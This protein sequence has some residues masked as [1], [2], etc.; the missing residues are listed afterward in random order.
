MLTRN[1]M[2]LA[3]GE[4][5]SRLPLLL[6]EVTLARLLGP[7]V[8]GIWSIIQTFATY[9]N[10]LH[11]GVSSS[12]A[13]REPGLIELGSPSEVLANRAAAY[14]FQIMVIVVVAGLLVTISSVHDDAFDAIGGLSTALALLVVILAQQ[15]TIS[16]QASALNEYKVIASSIARLVYAFAF[17][18]IGLFVVR[19]DP[20]LLWLTLGWAV[21]LALAL[22]LLNV[23]A[24]GILIFPRLDYSRTISMLRDGFPIMV[25]GLLRFGLMSVDKIA[26]FWVAR[27]EAVG[28]YGI[29]SLAASVT[30]LFGSMIARVSLPTLLRLRERT[31]SPVL[32]QAEFDRMVGLIQLLTY[33]ALFTVCAVSPLLIHFVLPDYEPAVRAIGILAIAGGFTGLAQAMSDVTMS[34]GIKAAVLA[35][36]V[37]TLLLE[38]L[39]LGVAWNIDGGIESMAASVLAA[40]ILMSG[41]S[42]W[43]C[44]RA[45]GFA[46][47]V[48]RRRLIT[49]TGYATVVMVVCLGVLEIQMI[50]MAN[51]KSDARPAIIFNVLLSLMACL[52][53]IIALKRFRERSEER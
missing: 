29:G 25:Q 14:G 46:H 41:R 7:A 27:P 23:I 45:I 18:A 4:L 38:L 10:F 37:I 53:L 47:D 2:R 52:G 16:T 6:L 19:F 33:S 50:C 36:T 1:A 15:F 39:F 17:L 24:R 11:F 51:L 3:V 34:L 8:Y 13:R 22:M 35:N 43:L 49:L 20:P 31:N 21:A 42:V 26:V 28:F 30:G 12:M 32:M 5:G 48:A 44:M 40:M 9:G